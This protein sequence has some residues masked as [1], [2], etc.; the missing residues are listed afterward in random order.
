M[1]NDDLNRLADINAPLFETFLTAIDTVA[2]ESLERVCLQT[3]GKVYVICCHFRPN[4]LFFWK[5]AHYAMYDRT[6]DAI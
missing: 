1:H 5:Y 4:A 2:G 6:T 3:G